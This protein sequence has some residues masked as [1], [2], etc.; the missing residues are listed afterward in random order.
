M[1]QTLNP[2][3]KRYHPALVA[4]HWLIAILIITN[5]ILAGA[6]EGGSRTALGGV[7]LIYIHMTF[8]VTILLLLITRLVLRLSTQRPAPADIGNAF[9]NKIGELTHWALYLLIFGMTITG[10]IL[11][12]ENGYLQRLFGANGVFGFGLGGFHGLILALLMLLIL[13]HVGAALFHQFFRKDNLLSR[14]WF[15][16]RGE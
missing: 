3:P 4:L 12:S 7:P 8:G 5:I 9:L 15:G 2:N 16:K 14:M 1:S 11:S 10:I 6:S 13:M